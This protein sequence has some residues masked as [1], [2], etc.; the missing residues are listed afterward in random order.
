MAK[1]IWS[2]LCSKAL[3]DKNT[4]SVSLMEIVE[5]IAISPLPPNK[6]IIVP[7]TLDLV[8]LACRSDPATPEKQMARMTLLTPSGDSVEGIRFELDLTGSVRCRATLHMDGLPLEGVGEYTFLLE[9]L[10][11]ESEEWTEIYRLPLEVAERD[12]EAKAKA[13]EA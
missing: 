11:E 6:Q 13:A 7:L 9:F 1:H 4:N 8:T 2:I 10:D 12:A 3:T 5:Q